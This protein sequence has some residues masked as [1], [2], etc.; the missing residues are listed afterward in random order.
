MAGS[1]AGR[2]SYLADEPASSG[3]GT[4]WL[5][6]AAPHHLCRIFAPVSRPRRVHRPY[7][8]C[9]ERWPRGVQRRFPDRPR[10]VVRGRRA[11]GLAALPKTTR[12]TQPTP[13]QHA[14]YPPQE[15]GAHAAP[16]TPHA[17][18]LRSR[19]PPAIKRV[20]GGTDGAPMR[21]TAERMPNLV[22]ARRA[23]ISLAWPLPASRPVSV[24]RRVPATARPV[25]HPPEDDSCSA[26]RGRSGA[27]GAVTTRAVRRFC[28]PQLCKRL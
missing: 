18:A 7:S 23:G 22:T 16:V 25:R 17:A 3:P 27:Q 8:L 9:P 28:S 6:R 24:R 2:A 19:R 12:V 21:L 4:A 13:F 20:S 11:P 1:D 10:H 26:P 5:C 15:R 14:L